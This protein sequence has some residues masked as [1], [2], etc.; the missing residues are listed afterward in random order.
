MTDFLGNHLWQSTA[1][2]IVAGLLTLAFRSNRAGVRF[3]LWFAASIKFVVPFAVLM[4]VCGRIQWTADRRTAVAH[5]AP[6]AVSSTV[7]NAA[8][9]FSRLLPPNPPGDAHQKRALILAGLWIAGFLLLTARRGREWLRIRS[10]VRTARTVDL[11]H[12]IETR[13][14]PGRLEPGVV[15]M[16]RPILLLPEGLTE[17]LRPSQMDA[18]I[19]HELCHVRR[20]DNL[21]GAI[22]MLVEALFWFYPPVW[23]IGARLLVERER[24]CDE[25]VLRGGSEPAIYADAI[26][27]VCRHCVESPLPC[28][29]AVSGA[30]IKQRIEVIM[31]NRGSLR[32]SATKKLLLAGAAAAAV[33]IPIIT[34]TAG[35]LAR[36]QVSPKFDAIS[37]QPCTPGVGLGRGRSGF[38]FSPGIGPEP[39]VAGYLGRSPGHL[40]ISCASIITLVNA[41]YID[42]GNG[43]LVNDSSG[44]GG[45]A[46]RIRNVPDWAISARFNIKASTADPVANG[47]TDGPNSPAW[48]IMV[49]PMLRSLLEDRF[50]LQLRDVTEQVPMYALKVADTGLKLKPTQPRDCTPLIRG[51][52]MKRVGFDDVPYCSWIGWPSHGPNRTVVAG[53]VSIDRIADMLSSF[54]MDRHVIDRT[55]LA[56]TYNARLEY[57]P[58]ERTPCHFPAGTSLCQVDSASAIPLAQTIFDALES[59]L[60]LKLEPVQAEHEFIVLDRVEPPS[61]N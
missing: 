30:N 4:S 38:N 42:F 35:S 50:R 41:A 10:L 56:G 8:E 32:L 7:A 13:I 39:G 25:E 36:A 11:H 12:S 31:K 54:V 34:G 22:H 18:L 20:R 37:I 1:F 49:G 14:A 52:E 43:N 2:A 26:L 5:V 21:L 60:G 3:W 16:V 45:A 19:A 51:M 53:Q 33:A 40:D 57:A 9:P 27:S 58:N 15:G 59:Q 46:T 48:R 23:W 6:L 17:Q 44:P 47:D 61:P 29:S 24:A 55:G 28:V